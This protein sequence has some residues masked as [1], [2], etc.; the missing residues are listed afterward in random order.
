MKLKSLRIAV[1]LALL[2]AGAA[3]GAPD[4]ADAAMAHDLQQLRTLIEQGADVDEAQ[5]DGSTALHWAVQWNEPQAVEA[6]LEAGA[7]A[8]AMT[9]LGAT[10]LYLAALSGNA[11]MIEKLLEAGADATETVLENEE[12]V[13][14]FAARSGS[15]DS[16]QLLLDA[17]VEVDA[18]EAYRDTTALHWA[19]EQGHTAVV[20]LL[21]EHEA[22]P[23]LRSKLIVPESGGFGNAIPSGGLTPLIMASREGHLETAQALLDGG[24]LVNQQ[25]GGGHTPLLTA[26]QNG[27]TALATLLLERGADPSLANDQGWNPLYLAV[28]GRTIEVGTMPTPDTT[29]QELFD[30][31]ELLL[32]KGAMVNA[33]ISDNTEV[34]NAIRAT[35]LEEDGGTAFLRA[36]MGGDLPVMRLLL[37]HGAD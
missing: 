10:P 18:K 37:E 17:G 32:Q 11:A 35:W 7:D 21:L 30:L 22:N 24:A 20:Q 36:A 25:S 26:V 12:T 31:I 6:L 14:M 3:L 33:R 16:V 19:A 5:P 27:H 4:V 23:N 34:R 1:L 13:L 9:P 28:K 8:E 29:D 2:P 15:L